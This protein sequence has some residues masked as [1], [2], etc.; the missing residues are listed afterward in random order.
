MSASIRCSRCNYA[1]TVEE[2]TAGRH[3]ICPQCGTPV[4]SAP[5]VAPAPAGSP[6]IGTS[7][8]HGVSS[9]DPQ[10]PPVAAAPIPVENSV[11]VFGDDTNNS[12]G[13]VEGTDVDRMQGPLIAHALV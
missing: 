3:V 2:E 11:T 5:G 6:A 12:D 7:A 4:L 13:D 10:S 8:T 1:V 9:Y